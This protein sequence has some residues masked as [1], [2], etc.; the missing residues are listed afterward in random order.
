MNLLNDTS[1]S[2]FKVFSNCAAILGIEEVFS[3]LRAVSV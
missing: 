2:L 1:D 3:L